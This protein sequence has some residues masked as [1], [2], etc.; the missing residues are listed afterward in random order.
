MQTR[1]KRARDQHNENQDAPTCAVCLS[2]FEVGVAERTNWRFDCSHLVCSDCD[3]ALLERAIHKCPTCRAIRLGLT[4][5]DLVSEQPQTDWSLIAGPISY[6]G[7]TRMFFPRQDDRTAE[8]TASERAPLEERVN[9]ALTQLGL[10]G[11][12][13]TRQ[14]LTSLLS[15]PSFRAQSPRPRVF[16]TRI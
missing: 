16:L 2:D 13:E 10:S 15:F 4:E 9:N 3:T 14:L 1:A 11:D 12:E 7:G 8:L 5:E 6:S